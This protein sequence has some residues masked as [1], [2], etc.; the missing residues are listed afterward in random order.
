MLDAK[1]LG[2][3][4]QTCRRQKKITA[5]KLA[6]LVDVSVPYM[7]ELER[8]AKTP[9]MAIFIEIANVLDVSADK[10]LC[11][12]IKEDNKLIANELYDKIKN[13]SPIKLKVV[14]SVLDTL[15][16]EL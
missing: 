7:R 2:K 13:L 5:E 15:I 8:G 16:K 4:I 3:R 11:D 10:L 6:E 1:L 14:Q 12:S 9:S